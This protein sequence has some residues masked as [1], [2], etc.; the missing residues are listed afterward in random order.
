MS[1]SALAPGGEI[2]VE[3]TGSGQLDGIDVVVKDLYD[4]AGTV[5]GAGNPT[6][7]AG[8]V[9]TTHAAAVTALLRAGARI[10]GKT[11]TDELAMGMFGVNTHYG[12]PPNPAAPDRVP[13]G[14]SSGSAS[15]VA[16]GLAP[17]GIGTDTGGSIRV[18]ASFCGLFGLRP[19]HGRIDTAGVR[20]MAPGFDTVGLLSPDP[21]L[22]G[23]AFR[24]LAG[25]PRRPRAISS[26]VLLTDLLAIA[27]EGIAERTR[28]TA[29]RW[30]KALGL[31]LR[32]APLIPARHE[33]A[34]DRHG[35]PP[36][37]VT[38]FWPLMS[39]QLWL[40][41]GDWVRRNRP[42]LGTG[43]EDR[44]LAAAGI[45]DEQVAAAQHQREILHLRF[46]QLLSDAVAVLPTTVDVA[47][48]RSSSHDDLMAYRD[49]NL[50]LI[51]PASL[52]GSP[53]L[54]VPARVGSGAGAGRAG[55]IPF[56]ISLLGLPGDD[57][58]LFGMADALAAR[59]G[60]LR[61]QWA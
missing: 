36:D 17:L 56:G 49:R 13:G 27:T 14:S 44:I 35:L 31:R 10:V 52:C 41:N 21:A 37:L 8:P 18:P 40:S 6:L 7:A 19:T 28:A 2:T 25:A 23:S 1:A 4:V 59:E 30:A 32:E 51:V 11:A 61:E 29:V 38:V 24:V 58:L 57:E 45:T 39:R 46:A 60:L 34:P 53:Q 9:A 16:A 20:P 15:A 26:V 48:L 33:Q 43:I 54:S 3:P 50:R 42:L 12:T 55:H 5:T 47:P 22:I